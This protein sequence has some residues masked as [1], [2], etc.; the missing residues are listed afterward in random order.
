VKALI[1]EAY[2]Q[3]ESFNYN[4][5]LERLES[6]E[7]KIRQFDLGHQDLRKK[8]RANSI[9]LQRLS[10]LQ[11]S[12]DNFQ[13]LKPAEGAISLAVDLL[14]NAERRAEQGNYGDAISR[15]YRSGEVI[16][17]HGLAALGMD[18]NKAVLSLETEYKFLAESAKVYDEERKLPRL[19]SLLDAFILLHGMG[20]KLAEGIST[21]EL[22][23]LRETIEERDD[24]ITGHGT[25]PAS[26]QLY[27]KLR[28]FA[29]SAIRKACSQ[30][31][32]KFNELLSEHAH[33]KKLEF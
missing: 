21:Q 32:L 4:A 13:S 10:K 25:K 30:A 23:K 14:C 12:G 28:D 9:A 7:K 8:I 33:P 19:F 22:K 5:A 11:K 20:D 17:Q 3:W 29:K 6:G 2:A 31:G 15:A 27:A 24:S 16:A 1:C 18:A 26:P